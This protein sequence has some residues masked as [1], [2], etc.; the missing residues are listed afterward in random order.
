MS[1][2][3]LSNICYVILLQSHVMQQ[4]VVKLIVRYSAYVFV[5]WCTNDI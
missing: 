5:S 3:L 4:T 1:T 2:V